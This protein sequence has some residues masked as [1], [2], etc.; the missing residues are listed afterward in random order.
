MILPIELHPH[1]VTAILDGRQHQ[2]RRP[3]HPQPFNGYSDSEIEDRLMRDDAL[4]G[5]GSVSQI[6]NGAWHAGFLELESVYG[7]IGDLLWVS[8]DYWQD[9]R[10][11]TLI[12]PDAEPHKTKCDP[13]KSGYSDCGVEHAPPLGHKFWKKYPAATLPQW[14]SRLTLLI[15]DIRIDR[16]QDI[17]EQEA[18]ASGTEPDNLENN[19]SLVSEHLLKGSLT[20]DR[21]A[22]EWD[23]VNVNRGYG[24]SANPWVWVIDFMAFPR[25]VNEVQPEAAA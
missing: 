5:L 10:D 14:G 23:S 4:E 7:R 8:E 11:Q 21:F 16:L 18:I 6:V 17:N 1:E 12:I 24:W 13:K 9:T 15:K 25:N 3:I 2:L 22:R 19:A 20:I